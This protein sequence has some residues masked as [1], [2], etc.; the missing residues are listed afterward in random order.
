[1]GECLGECIG[2]RLVKGVVDSGLDPSGP[3]PGQCLARAG[4]AQQG[5]LPACA[6]HST[7]TPPSETNETADTAAPVRRRTLLLTDEVRVPP[8]AWPPQL[9]AELPV[10]RDA[11]PSQPGS[12]AAGPAADSRVL[13]RSLLLA[14]LLHVW[15]A[16]LVGS[17]PPGTA[18]PGSG[19]GGAINVRLGGDV[20]G[21]PM[22]TPSPGVP[23]ASGGEGTAVATRQGG[24][25]RDRAPADDAPEGAARLGDWSPAVPDAARQDRLPAARAPR[26]AAAPDQQAGAPAPPGVVTDSTATPI[27]SAA[28]A[29]LPLPAPAPSTSPEPVPAFAPDVVQ[30]PAA[31]PAPTAALSPGMAAPP[32]AMSPLPATPMLERPE[33]PDTALPAAAPL[34]PTLAATPLSSSARPSTSAAL[35]RVERAQAPVAP[36]PIVALPAPLA[37]NKAVPVDPRLATPVVPAA[38]LQPNAPLPQTTALPGPVVQ[39]LPQLTPFPPL[40]TLAPPGAVAAL[41]AAT[42]ASPGPAAARAAAPGQAASAAGGVPQ[43]APAQGQPPASVPGVA[44]ARPAPGAAPVPSAGPVP[45]VRPALTAP[46]PSGVGR[47]AANAG[48]QVGRDMATPATAAASTPRLNLDLPRSRGG[49]LSSQGSRGVLQLMARPPEVK[50][51]LAT[52]IEKAGKADCAK[53]YAGAGLLAVVPLAVDALKKDSGCKW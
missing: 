43:T 42:A 10:V 30:A 53:A 36:L 14:L 38:P 18:D 8:T 47:G 29:P 52:D 23:R 32:Q 19:V 17:V 44:T 12:N 28:T 40:A 9:R 46:L 48:E 35:P 49:E 33:V 41:P 27:L 25:V 16:L 26:S 51:K 21:P 1:M 3:V 15:L 4:P 24:A 31:R 6:M 37:P 13:R 39:P 2:E 20:P 22:D 5:T 45:D 34:L 50:S 11:L 7:S